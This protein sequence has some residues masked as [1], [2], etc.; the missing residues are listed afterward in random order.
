[1]VKQLPVEEG[2]ELAEAAEALGLASNRRTRSPLAL[3]A[4]SGLGGMDLGLEAAGYR[5]VGAIELDELARSS[6]R[7]N[8][9]GQW[10][11]I[12]EDIADAA[13]R[14][15]PEDLGLDRGELALLAGGPSCTASM[16]SLPRRKSLVR[17]RRSQ[18][19]DRRDQTGARHPRDSSLGPTGNGVHSHRRGHLHP[20]CVSPT[21]IPSISR[22]E[23]RTLG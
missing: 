12:G 15:R 11:I 20:G 5:L 17:S 1:M 2:Y 7:K 14:L 8:R 23:R 10:S 3:S 18:R 13:V 16:A 21:P 4:F 19:P 6:L 9:D 22:K